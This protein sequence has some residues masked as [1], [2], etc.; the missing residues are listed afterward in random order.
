MT[1]LPA[2]ARR[3]LRGPG[4]SRLLERCGIEPCRYWIL[5][6]LFETLGARLELAGMGDAASMRAV[7][8]LWFL[9][10][11][12]ISLVLV[13]SGSAPGTYLGIFLALTV[14]QLGVVLVAEVAES[15]VNPVDGLILAHQPVNGATWSGAKLTHLVRIV[16]YIVAGVNG[17]PALAGVL[18]SHSDAYS[19]LLY[20]PAHFAIA[21]ATGLLVALLCC[22]LFGWLVRFVPVR[23]LKAAAAVAQALPML[24][25]FGFRYLDELL[26]DVEARAAAMELPAEWSAAVSAVPGGLPALLGTGGAAV[27]A[28]VV[29]FGLRA[30]S[31]DHLIRASSLMRSGAR[32]RRRGRRRPRV[33]PWIGRIA[34]GQPGRAGYEYLRALVVRDWQFLRSMAMNAPAPVVFLIVMLVVGREESPFGP[35]FAPAHFLPH[36][37]GMLILFVCLFLAYGNDYKGVWSFGV[38]PDSAFRPFARGIHA[39]LWLVLVALPNVFWLLVLAWSWGLRDAA[40]FSAC[41]TAAASVYLGVCLR[42]IAGIPF[43]RQMQPSRQVATFGLF[44]VFFL[45]AAV[46]VGLQYVLFRSVAAVVVVTLVVGAGAYLVTRVTLGD[47][48]SRMRASLRPVASGSMFR[49]A[50]AEDE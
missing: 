13:A 7:A 29:F 49:F 9:L 14:F 40:V 47:L 28:V 15:L 41:C 50:H 35:G 46:A 44:V 38:V 30:L 34:G 21:L 36:L 18:L 37:L 1:G 23:R 32:R 25:I 43:G 4:F 19:S 11:S 24:G 3:L 16:V 22:A 48:A 6:D 10:S 8:V 27:A 39:A 2:F 5:V 20:P 45:A 33:G 12:V 42:L 31:R 17:A 26:A